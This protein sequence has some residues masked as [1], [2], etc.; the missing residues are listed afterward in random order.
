[1]TLFTKSDCTR[2]MELK[3]QFDMRALG[4]KVEKLDSDNAEALSHLAWHGLVEA[5]RKHLPIL[6]LDDCS[7]LIDYNEIRNHLAQEAQKTE[8]AC[9]NLFV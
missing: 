3:N 2:C 6:V 9:V 1:M 7:S 8:I 5:A 4:I